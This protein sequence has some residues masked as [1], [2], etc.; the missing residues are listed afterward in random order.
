MDHAAYEKLVD[1][2][3][4]LE[5]ALT[6]HMASMTPVQRITGMWPEIVFALEELKY[7]IV[8]VQPKN[9][10]PVDTDPGVQALIDAGWLGEWDGPITVDDLVRT[11]KIVRNADKKG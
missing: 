5:I 4:D 11:V 6:E 3:T 1:K 2:L 10:S 8:A 9:T 7:K